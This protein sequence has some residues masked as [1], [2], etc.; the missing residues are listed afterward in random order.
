M[1]CWSYHVSDGL[2]LLEFLGWCDDLKMEPLLAVYAGYSLQGAHV[3]VGADL[4]PYVQEALDEIEYCTGD[5]DT[6]WG[7]RRAQDGHPQPFVIHYIE[8]GNED[9]YDRSNTYDGRFTQIFKAIKAKYPSLL[10]IATA[11]SVHSVTPD[12]YDDHAYPRPQE[13]LRMV[14]K[15]DHYKANE[16]QGLLW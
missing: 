5:A 13:M 3:N 2:G 16:A 1:G 9:S 8:I 6:T 10:C 15:Y 7:K 14:Q 4:E 11:R 12:L